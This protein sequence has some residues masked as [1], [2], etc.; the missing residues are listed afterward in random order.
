METSANWSAVPLP[1]DEEDTKF[2]EPWQAEAFSLT[3]ELY[4]A[5]HFSWPDWVKVFSEE[6]KAFPASTSESAGDAYYRQWAAALEKMAASRGLATSDEIRNRT[7][8]WRQAYLNTPH[9]Y[10][11][12]LVNASCRPA[13]HPGHHH[14]H[15]HHHDHPHSHT[16]VAISPSRTG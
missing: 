5:G 15:H 7:E 1:I 14:A 6:I 10:P 12:D 8:E 11:V 13:H 2:N 16:P 9:G 3:V 4:K